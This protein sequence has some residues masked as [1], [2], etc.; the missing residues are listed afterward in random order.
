MSYNEQMHFLIKHVKEMREELGRNPSMAE[1]KAKFPR[2]NIKILFHS[3]EAF[4][5][6]AGLV[7]PEPEDITFLPSPPKILVFD[8][9]TK[10][11]KVWSWGIWEQNIGLDMIIEDW[12]VLCWAAKWIGNDQ[13]FYQDLS[14]NMDYTKDELIVRGIWEL[15]NECSVVVTQN[16]IR[17]DVKKLNAKFEEYGLGSPSPYKHIDALRIVKKNFALTSNKLEFS[18]HKFNEKYKKLS[19]GKFAGM[20]LWI[21]CLKGNQEAWAEMKLYNI[22]DVLALEELYLNNLRKWDNTINFGVYT[23]TGNTC[24]NCGSSDLEKKE[25]S[26]TKTGAFQVYQCNSCKSFCQ[27]RHN[28]LSRS[29][30]KGLL[31]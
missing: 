8:I 19:H 1:F 3:F 31:K 16:G 21:E 17:F 18:T 5:K 11:M 10:P 9:E 20:K 29:V 15:L 4:L 28:E 30:T 13:I 27:S 25:F 7:E 12:S 24:P 22:H 6:A 14:Q 26:Y 2:I 23:A